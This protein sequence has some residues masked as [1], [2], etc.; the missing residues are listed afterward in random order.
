MIET[1]TIILADIKKMLGIEESVSEFDLDIKSAINSA[2]FTLY[3]LGI[4][5]LNPITIDETT[6]WD[7]FDTTAPKEVI[8]EY[9]FLKVKIIFDPPTSSFVMDA[10]K[11]RIAELEFRMNIHVDNG[12]GIING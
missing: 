4:G 6:T 1:D 5:L 2:F 8:R 12:G 11:D 3:Q 10:Q 7:E 9:L